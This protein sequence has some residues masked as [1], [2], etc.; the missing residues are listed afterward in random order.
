MGRRANGEGTIYRR[1]DRRWDASAFFL[2]SSGTRKRKHFY[3]ATRQEAHQ[4]LVAAQMQAQ[5]GMPIPDKDWRLADYFDYWLENVV[6]L[7]QQPAT[8]ERSKSVV[9]LYLKPSFGN[10]PL[11]RL[12]VPVVQTVLNNYRVQGRSLSIVTTMR[13]ILSAA[14]TQAEREELVVRNV[15]R[16]VKLPGYKPETDVVPWTLD[17]AKQFLNAGQS[18]PHS[19]VFV[20]LLFYGLRRG[21]ALGLRWCDVDFDKGILHIRQQVHRVGGELLQGPLKTRASKRDLPLLDPVRHVL[22]VRRKEQHTARLTAHGEWHSS[23]ED[24]ELVMTTGSGL[25]IEPRNLVRSFHRLCRQHRI[26]RIRVHDLRHTT[27]TLLKTLGVPDRDRQLIMGHADIRTTQQVYE[28]D[29][30]ESR[31][32]ALSQVAQLFGRR[33]A[34]IGYC[35]Q[36]LTSSQNIVD[37]L[38]SFLSGATLGIRTPDPRF[39]KAML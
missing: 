13:T 10:V 18:D 30:L 14:L 36:I 19:V 21:E 2:T 11:S 6:R 24:Q 8:Y 23:N 16:R 37:Q 27:A 9:R 22:E 7:N 39:T 15:A 3:G 20:L 4:K 26:R 35:R 38:T 34:E 1:P 12:T 29:T 25:P 32:H 33:T 5:Q 28:H 17:E 31:R